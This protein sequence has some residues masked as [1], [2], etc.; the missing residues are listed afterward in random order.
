MDA[1]RDVPRVGASPAGTAP[2]GD[3]GCDADADAAGLLAV[4]DRG[5]SGGGG[6]MSSD[7][8]TS[9]RGA[10]QHMASIAW[11]TGISSISRHAVSASSA[12]FTSRTVTLAMSRDAMCSPATA[13]CSSGDAPIAPDPS[14]SPSNPC[15]P[16]SVWGEVNWR[17]CVR[18]GELFIKSK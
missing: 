10:A 15:A 3:A 9:G 4:G 16:A 7:A 13:A 14:S 1:P 17:G 5:T 2:A 8:L 18:L 12:A 11:C 6:T